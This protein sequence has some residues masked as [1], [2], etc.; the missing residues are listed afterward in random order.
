MRIL[1]W[2]GGT[3]RAAVPGGELRIIPAAAF[4]QARREALTLAETEA[5]TGLALN[6]CV[7]AR[8]LYRFGRRRFADGRAVLRRLSAEQIGALTARYLKLAGT[9]DP[10]CC[11]DPAQIAAL[12]QALAE[13]PY[14]RLKWRVLQAFSVLP[15]ER[16]A[17]E[18]TAG[19]Y[20][21]CALQLELDDEDRL[22]S[23]CPGCRAAAETARC[24][25]CGNPAEAETGAFDEAR[26]EELKHDGR[27]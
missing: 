20:L 3:R 10:S 8:A 13:D 12:R 9:E 24:P 14:E 15:S 19:D 22:A 2:R 17:Q 27:T 23:L 21:Y 18:M 26:F 1:A 16:R 5:E 7:L 6:A 25:V 11:G 4:L